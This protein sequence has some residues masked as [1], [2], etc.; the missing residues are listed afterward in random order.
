MFIY[1]RFNLPTLKRNKKYK[2]SERRFVAIFFLLWFKEGRKLPPFHPD[3]FCAVLGFCRVT[4]NVTTIQRCCQSWRFAIRFVGDFFFLV[5][6]NDDQENRSG[7]CG[8]LCKNCCIGRFFFFFAV[9]RFTFKLKSVNTP[10][11]GLERDSADSSTTHAPG[12]V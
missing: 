3:T 2:M 7:H 5:L 8:A 6:W 1:C 12:R 11:A 10:F 9:G 4:T